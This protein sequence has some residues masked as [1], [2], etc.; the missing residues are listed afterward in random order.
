VKGLRANRYTM[1]AGTVSLRRSVRPSCEHVFVKSE[2]REAARQL[3]RDDGLP[4]S[5]IAV[6]L[7]VSKSSV[8][9]WVRDV[10][11]R[12]EQH[13]ALRLLNPLYNA[14]VRGQERR[15]E[16][17]RAARLAAQEHGREL[18][19]RG[20]PLH[21][22]GCMLH[23]A[24]GAKTRNSVIFVNSDPDMIALFL[25]FLRQ[26]YGVADEDV[27]LSVNVHVAAGRDS[28][29]VTRWWVDRLGLPPTCARAPTV[30]A[31]S[32][33]SRRRRGNM[34]PWGTAR[35]AV[36]STFIA[37]SIFGAIQEYAGAVRPEWVD[38]R[39]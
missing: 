31:V 17:A 25:R 36:H 4:L 21:I 33:A 19:R 2:A 20:D 34:L 3:R 1:G 30:N 16:T 32:S 6:R 18:A 9:R 27:A 28:A 35:V 22:Q 15:R 37:Q 14:Q 39:R 24:E 13:A 5:A 29:D 23:W 8:S 26:C 7:G 10:E 12:P 38:L 11:L